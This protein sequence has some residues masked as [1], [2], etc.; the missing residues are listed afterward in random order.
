ME[1]LNQIK[2]RGVVGRSEISTFQS[3][4]VCNFSVVTDYSTMD[5]EH[6][7][8]IESTWFNVSCWGGREGV[9]DLYAIQK[10]NWVQVIGRLRMR[11]YTTQENEE[12]TIY[13][14]LARKVDLLPREDTL[15]QPQRDW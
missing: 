15:M 14:V 13:D 4:Q 12:K 6:N 2:L 5:R 3:G 9:P 8:V 1:F 7:P 10:G 11:R